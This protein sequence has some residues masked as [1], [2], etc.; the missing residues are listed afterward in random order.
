MSQ[1]AELI[2]RAKRILQNEEVT[3]VFGITSLL[4]SLVFALEASETDRIDLRNR[5]AALVR[6]LT[7]DDMTPAV[8]RQFEAILKD[9]GE[10]VPE[11]GAGGLLLGLEHLVAESQR[12]RASGGRRFLHQRDEPIS[13]T[14]RRFRVEETN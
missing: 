4:N 14:T 8:A 1:W 5:V 2:G 10:Y 6:L 7:P 9:D 13:A 11:V 12:L 3:D